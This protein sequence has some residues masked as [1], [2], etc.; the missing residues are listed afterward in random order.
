[1]DEEHPF[2]TS[3][4]EKR[5]RK[6]KICRS[7]PSLPAEKASSGITS[8]FESRVS[9]TTDQQYL[10]DKKNYTITLNTLLR[11]AAEQAGV[12]LIYWRSFQLHKIML[13]K[14]R[15]P[16]L[17]ACAQQTIVPWRILPIIVKEHQHKIH[18]RSSGKKLLV[19]WKRGI[20]LPIWLP[21]T[22]LAQ[23]L[24]KPIMQVIR[25][26]CSMEEWELLWTDYVNHYRIDLMPNTACQYRCSDQRYQIA[27]RNR[28]CPLL[29]PDCSLNQ[30]HDSKAQESAPHCTAE[31][32]RK[33]IWIPKWERGLCSI[34]QAEI[35]F[36]DNFLGVHL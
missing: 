16:Q 25:P 15:L 26:H 1:M 9:S 24:G 14:V 5:Y 22:M 19:T 8:K 20:C 34:S 10:S 36:S 4:I 7:M 32:G 23:H 29:Y 21:W 11:K 33:I 27:L 2:Q 3:M 17:N 31:R 13:E 28:R 18:S 35:S 30:W 6:Q 12:H